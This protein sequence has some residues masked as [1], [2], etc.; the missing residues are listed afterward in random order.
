MYVFLVA[1]KNIWEV[2]FIVTSLDRCFSLW[3]SCKRKNIYKDNGTGNL[4]TDFL[5]ERMLWYVSLSPKVHT[6]MTV[7]SM[8][9]LRLWNLLHTIWIKRD[10]LVPSLTTV[11]HEHYLQWHLDS[12]LP[13]WEHILACYN[14]RDSGEHKWNKHVSWACYQCQYRLVIEPHFG[15]LFLS[16]PFSAGLE[17]T[18]S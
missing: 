9:F 13:P 15:H 4:W 5:F 2:Y 7:K 14:F 16:L 18:T 11:F 1:R 12:W 17:E 8:G 10:S 6:S 3:G